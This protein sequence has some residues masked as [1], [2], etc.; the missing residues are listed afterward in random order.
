MWFLFS[1]LKSFPCGFRLKRACWHISPFG[2][3]FKTQTPGLMSPGTKWWRHSAKEAHLSLDCF[4]EKVKWYF[5]S[6]KDEMQT[7]AY[8]WHFAGLSGNS[9]RVGCPRKD[10]SNNVPSLEI[11]NRTTKKTGGKYCFLAQRLFSV[12]N[13]D[14]RSSTITRPY[15][16]KRVRE[17]RW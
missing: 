11:N 14:I 1:F 10:M 8:C 7:I 5:T 12:Y 3:A 2:F 16:W 4:D 15:I 6:W 17:R 9:K 13:L